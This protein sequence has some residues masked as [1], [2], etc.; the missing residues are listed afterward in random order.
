MI[1]LKWGLLI[2]KTQ[3]STIAVCGRI[4]VLNFINNLTFDNV[5]FSQARSACVNKE[6]VTIDQLDFHAES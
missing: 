6:K 4:T 1:F 2:L 5:V 3:K